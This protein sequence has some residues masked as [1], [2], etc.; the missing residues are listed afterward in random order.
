MFGFCTPETE[1]IMSNSNKKK[2]AKK[3]Q[4]KVIDT[5]VISHVFCCCLESINMEGL[6]QRDIKTVAIT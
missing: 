3:N 4:G 5:V 6:M 1:L 2:R